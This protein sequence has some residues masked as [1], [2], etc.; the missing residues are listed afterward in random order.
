MYYLAFIVVKCVLTKNNM[1]VYPKHLIRLDT[2]Y[3]LSKEA[4]KLKDL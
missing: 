4:G 2:G 3:C 1:V